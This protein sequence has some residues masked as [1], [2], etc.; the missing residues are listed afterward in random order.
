M[1][2]VN[3]FNYRSF[4]TETVVGCEVVTLESPNLHPNVGLVTTQPSMTVPD[5]VISLED[6]LKRFVR[7]GV[8]EGLA[9]NPV[10]TLDPDMDNLENLDKAQLMA[11]SKENKNFLAEN[12]KKAKPGV[13]KNLEQEILE[14][15]GEEKG[16][17]EEKPQ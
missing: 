4:Y 11:L 8:L 10:F 17:T 2:L 16:D 12:M 9:K 15:K 14:V 3:W 1:M 13:Q 6:I 7:T 5:M